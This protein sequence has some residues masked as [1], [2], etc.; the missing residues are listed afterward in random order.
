VIQAE[1]A[2][3]EETATYTLASATPKKYTCK[4]WGDT[5]VEVSGPND[6]SVG[7]PLYRRDQ[8]KKSEAPVKTATRFV[9][10][11]LYSW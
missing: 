9:A 11:K 8:L 6:Y 2:M 4:F 5:C 1:F 7:Y 3:P 10:P